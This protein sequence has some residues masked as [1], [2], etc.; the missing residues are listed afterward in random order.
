MLFNERGCT[1]KQTINEYQ[2]ADA[3]IR[4]NRG[5]NFSREGLR[6]L[7]EYLTD[8]EEDTGEEIELDVIAICCE[9]GEFTLSELQVEYGDHN[10]EEWSSLSEAIDWLQDRTTV[11]ETDDDSVIIQLF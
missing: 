11:I 5:D 1:M 9:F 6:A 3:F 8:I 7:Y 2:F 10:G 4:M